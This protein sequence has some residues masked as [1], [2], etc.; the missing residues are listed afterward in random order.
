M[1]Q[2]LT[3]LCRLMGH[4]QNGEYSAVLSTQTFTTAFNFSKKS[5]LQ[6]NDSELSPIAGLSGDDVKHFTMNSSLDKKS[7]RQLH[8]SNHKYA[9]EV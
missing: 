4:T 3:Q 1:P 8:C 6:E 5:D 2:Q 9:W 7:L